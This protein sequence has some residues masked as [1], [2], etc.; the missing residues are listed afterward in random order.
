MVPVALTARSLLGSPGLLPHAAPPCC[1]P[2]NLK[3]RH[4]LLGTGVGS[5]TG[6][7]VSEPHQAR[8]LVPEHAASNHFPAPLLSPRRV[9]YEVRTAGKS[10]GRNNQSSSL[11][12][13][14]S[15]LRGA[16]RAAIA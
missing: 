13:L 10:S 4:N 5:G 16:I 9:P 15:K 2:N 14:Q 7:T 8:F 12:H 1:R 6:R 3:Q 11:A